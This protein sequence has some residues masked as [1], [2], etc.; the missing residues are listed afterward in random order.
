MN[1]LNFKYLTLSL[2][3]AFGA[4]LS[5][6]AKEAPKADSPTVVY[7]TAGEIICTPIKGKNPDEEVGTIVMGNM[8]ILQVIDLLRNFSGRVVIPGESLPKTKLNFNS[9]GKL[10]RKDAIFALE[11]ILALNG[12][13]LRLMDNG[14]VRAISSK[15]PDNSGAPLIDNIPEG[16]SS[17]QIYSKI[18]KLK[19]FDSNTAYQRLRSMI[20]IKSRAAILNQPEI[21]SLIVTDSL[22]NL[23]RIEQVIT[24]LDQP[25]ES[26][27]ELYTFPVNHG[28][29]A[30]LRGSLYQIFRTELNNRL[31]TSYVSADSRTN[32]L[33]VVTHPSN[34]EFFKKIIE[35]LD[36]P[37][38]PFTTTEIIKIKEGNYGTIWNTI[39]GIVRHQ[40]SQFKRQGLISQERGEN[41]DGIGRVTTN[42]ER[43][44]VDSTTETEDTA[45]PAEIA[46]VDSDTGVIMT[47]DA[48]PELQFSPYIALYSDP[49]NMAFV[50]Y[51]TH[52]DIKRMQSLIDKL[53]IKSA[54]YVGSEVFKIQYARATDIRNVV[55][56]TVVTQRR[57]FSRAGIQSGET[58]SQADAATAG[59][60]QQ[61]F[62]YSKFV[63]TIADNRNNTI[64][65]QGTQQD[66]KQVK[67]LIDKLDVESSPLTSNEVIY[68]KHAEANTLARVVQNIINQQ[69]S[70]F[71]R[72]RALSQSNATENSAPE[73]PEIGFEF[74]DYAI[75]NAD[76]RTNALFVYGTKRD[77]D[78]VKSIVIDS[79][80]PVEP[81]TDTQ[82]FSLTH[83]DATQIASLI[84]RVVSGQQRSLRQVRSESRDVAN[85]STQVESDTTS[86]SSSSSD[87]ASIVEGQE[88]L[89]FSNFI[90]IT[91]DRRSN[92]IIVYGTSA[93]IIQIKQL[94]AK[95]DIEVAPLTNSK[96]FLLEHT[97]ARSLYAVLNSVVR[98]QERALKQVRS[99]IREI[100]NVRADD[101]NL[102]EAEMSLESLQ[103]SPYVTIT[104]NSRNNSIIIY[105][106]D[107]DIAQL[108]VLIKVSDVEIAPKT[109]SRTFFIR[110]ADANDISTTLTNL[111]RQQQRVRESESTL[112]RIF[113]RDGQ[114]SGD[115]I[116]NFSGDETFSGDD[117]NNIS[118][119]GILTE[120]STDNYSDLFS[121]DEDL[122]FSPYVSIVADDRSNSV[123]AYGTAFDL[124]QI[125]DLIGQIDNV[126]PQVKIEV[127]IAEVILT[128]DQI[129]GLETFG[130]SYNSTNPNETAISGESPTLSTGSSP[131][132]DGG[133]ALNDFSLNAVFGLAKINNNV[134]VLSAPTITTTH[135]RQAQINVGE[136]RPII[137]SSASSLSSS[138]LVTRSTIE[139]RDIG[140]T[141]KVRPLVSEDGFIQMDV[142]QIVETVIDTQ[143]IDGNVQ[144]IIGT[145]RASSFVSVRN[146]EVIVMGGLQAVDSDDTESEVFGLSKIPIFGS[147]FQPRSNT[148]VVRELII[149]I[150]PCIVESAQAS[151]LITKE[152]LKN[153]SVTTEVDN[154]FSTGKFSG[155]NRLNTLENEPAEP[156][157]SSEKTASR[158]IPAVPSTNP[159]E[160]E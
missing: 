57:N 22:N 87:S 8:P 96:V 30:A 35:E 18:F 43:G 64:L 92:S 140:I 127:V 130:I 9:G 103:F 122:Q 17:E 104:P 145:R 16:I 6:Q 78:R 69:R 51:G 76:R 88:A 123:L 84:N 148:T 59:S 7:A 120:T 40:Q 139:F 58:S 42:G 132:F 124:E 155:Q 63:A 34:Y 136:S 11:N 91:A 128:D 77:I 23:K 62:E 110:H 14:F 141:L 99:S 36:Q 159:S 37:V 121:Y 19:Y 126:L 109:R 32:K 138:D 125:A 45:L 89:Q 61:G 21:N 65:V 54:P 129:S 118:N 26:R 116:D 95:I 107:S 156:S 49:S 25:S 101:P 72:K 160:T 105:G 135:N 86:S 114:S 75:V 100:R 97:Q 94:I 33:M 47:E 85:P 134:K 133:F 143:T 2:S 83:T 74:S 102:T 113:R 147:L 41:E 142:E 28:T 154:Y 71:S 112:T 131:A 5:L 12:V 31:R 52:A 29:A 48:S 79:D 119:S 67:D 39:R 13:T 50:V 144:P 70:L 10:K 4:V 44:T 106:T 55:E 111:I 80:I 46:T 158:L 68:L 137:T 152:A 20:S 1:D 117:N 73:S 81:I 38:A 15:D 108:E 115:D 56:Y 93:D 90:S 66:I 153:S 149:F 60:E 157:Q 27:F 150:R 53:D 82:V 3:L 24:L 146:E 151:E 98:G